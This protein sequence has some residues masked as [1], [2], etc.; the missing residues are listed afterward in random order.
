M[1]GPATAADTNAETGYGD[2]P[3]RVAP[4]V[5]GATSLSVDEEPEFGQ[6]DVDG[7]ELVYTPEADFVGT[8][9][10]TYTAI[11]PGGDSDPATVTIIVAAPDLAIG[12]ELPDG[13]QGHPY[14]HTLTATGGTEPCEFTAEDLPE[15]IT[16]E[17]GVL[18]GI[19]PTAGEHPITVTVAD[20]SRPEAVTVTV[21]LVLHVHSNEFT[22]VD[23]AEAGTDIE[24]TGTDLPD[25]DYDIVLTSDPLTL[26]QTTITDGVLEAEVTIPAETSAGEHTLELV[27]EGVVIGS[28]PLEVTAPPAAD[29]TPEPEL[30]DPTPEPEPTP[31]T[32]PQDE[33]P[34]TGATWTTPATLA[35]LLVTGGAGLLATR[36]IHPAR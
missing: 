6:A 11:G 12:D 32:Q 18:T 34:D 22:A 1:P 10:F 17:D 35:L 21:E 9:S 8:D 24:I 16:L 4:E 14:E 7:M 26:G 5:D 2:G 36:R 28:Q 27:R 15:G 25:G 13:I 31:E 23:S 30:T 29:P 19:P 20:S 3:V 33:L